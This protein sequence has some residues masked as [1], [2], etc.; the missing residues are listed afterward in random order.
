LVYIEIGLVNRALEKC[1]LCKDIE[2]CITARYTL[3]Q[4]GVA[5]FRFIT[6]TIPDWCYYGCNSAQTI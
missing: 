5:W 3:W 6:S 2:P 4:T 1:H